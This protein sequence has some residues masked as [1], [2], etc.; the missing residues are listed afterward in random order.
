MIVLLPSWPRIKPLVNLQLLRL[1]A[2]EGQDGA[3]N[4]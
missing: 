4:F 1:A 3:L 2:L